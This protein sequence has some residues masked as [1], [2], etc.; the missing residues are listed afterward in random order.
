[1]I[2][3]SSAGIGEGEGMEEVAVEVAVEVALGRECLAAVT[4]VTSVNAWVKVRVSLLGDVTINSTNR[5][6]CKMHD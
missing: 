1:M 5:D 2:L 4:D 6:K 3:H